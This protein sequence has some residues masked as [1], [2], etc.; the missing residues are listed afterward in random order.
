M[1]NHPLPRSLLILAGFA[2]A[3]TPARGA[4]THIIM[5]TWSS[6]DCGGYGVRV[7]V[8]NPGGETCTTSEKDLSKGETLA[9]RPQGCDCASMEVTTDSTVYIQTDH[10]DDFCPEKVFIKSPD[11]MYE[12]PKIMDWYDNA[13]NDKK[14]KITPGACITDWTGLENYLSEI[15]CTKRV[16]IP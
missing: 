10:G 15:A 9:W 8:V 11:S 13:S 2:F 7:K 4:I 16:D 1:A 12:T 3:T 14:H 5:T 6:N